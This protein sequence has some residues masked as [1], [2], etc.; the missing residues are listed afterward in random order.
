MADLVSELRLQFGIE[1]APA[2]FALELDDRD[3]LLNSPIEVQEARVFNWDWTRDEYKAFYTQKEILKVLSNG[4]QHLRLYSP[5]GM[6][7]ELIAT[8]PPVALKALNRLHFNPNFQT[9]NAVASEFNRRLLSFGDVTKLPGVTVTEARPPKPV[10]PT[11]EFVGRKADVVLDVIKF[12]NQRVAFQKYTY[13]RGGFETA[14]ASTFV[15]NDGR[16]IARPVWVP[17]LG[18][19]FILK[20]PATGSVVIRYLVEYDLWKINYGMASGIEFPEVQLAWLRGDIKTFPLP[21]VTVLAIAPAA[22]LV[23][24]AEFEKDVYPPGAYLSSWQ[25]KGYGVAQQGAVTLLSEQS[26]TTETLRVTDPD[27]E[28]NFIDV[29][30]A[31]SM[32]LFDADGRPFTYRFNP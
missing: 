14:Y 7:I 27:D 28:E 15:T 31:R 4:V 22:G 8:E 16:T 13:A 10:P 19:A 5:G 24:Q 11:A 20:E 18:G 30:R 26:R 2:T 3:A 9:A 25:T 6:Q 17:E 32:T 1:P 12:Q 29:Q 21:P 23:A